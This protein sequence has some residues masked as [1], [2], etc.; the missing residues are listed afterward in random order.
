MRQSKGTTNIRASWANV[1]AGLGLLILASCT[2]CHA[3]LGGSLHGTV[4]DSTGAVIPAAPVEIE[5]A[6]THTVE[7]VASNEDGS[8]TF[9]GLDA[10]TYQVRAH[11]AG[12]RLYAHDGLVVQEG[13]DQEFN[14]TL[15]VARQTA[16]ITVTE[17]GPH[18][19][20]AETAR[21]ETLA[22]GKIA[23]IPVNGRS[24][25]DLLAL[26]A[27]VT[28]VGSAQPNAVVMSGCTSTPPSGDINPGT[29]SISGQRETSN[30]FIV[31]GSDVE[32]GFNMGS[33]IIP[34]LDSLEDLRVLT[35]NFDAE[36]GNYAGGQVLITTKS[37]TNR[38]H[39]STFEFLRNTHLDARNYFSTDRAIYDQNQWGGTFGGP[40][41]NDKA[42]FF[43]DYQGTRLTQ[44]LETGLIAVPS[45]AA[46]AG[47]FEGVAG[48][49]SGTV[50]G[51]SWADH[52]SQSLGYTVH[53]GE[54]YY[55]Q[56][57]ATPGQCVFPNA[58]IPAS[59]WSE[60]ARHLLQNVP[61]ANQGEGSFSTSA[62]T[63]ELRDD[64]A[65]TRIDA[66]TP[67]GLL[68]AYYFFDD[69][70]MDSP[71][72]TAQGGANVP[73]FNALTLGRAQLA[74]LGMTRTI[75]SNKVN[76]THASFLR[77]SNDVGI[78]QGGV[79]PSLA[80]QGFLDAAGNPS[81]Y[82]LSPRIEGIENVSLND[83]T[84]GVDTTG[85]AEAN[86]TMQVTDDFS[87]AAGQHTLKI[88]GGLHLDGINISPDAIYNGSFSFT[89]TETGSDFADFLLGRPSSY[90]QGDSHSF[91]LRNKYIGLY[92]QD[93]WRVRPGMTLNYGLR[94]DLLPPW[95]EK[96]NQLQ[97]LVL[98]EKSQ[99]YPGAPEGLVFPGDPGVPS[100]LAPAAHTNFAPRLGF[101]YSP[102]F[103]S[104]LLGKVLGSAGTTSL[105]TGYGMFYTAFEGLSA[106]IMSANPPYGY[107]Y[108]TLS[109]PLFSNPFVTAESGESTFQPFPEPIPSRGATRDHPNASLDWSQYSPITGV[110]SFY[111]R[112]VTPY[113][114]SYT[115]SIERQFRGDTVLKVSYVG[116]QAHH[117]LVLV[118]A[119]PANPS[120][121]LGLSRP[122]QVM[123]GT[124]TCGPFG[125][126]GKY[127]STSGIVIHGTRA[128]FRSLFDAITYQKTLG[129]S[130]YNAAEVS[131]RHHSGP[132]D[133][134]LGY[135]FSKSL[136]QSS[137][138][139]EAANPL[140]PSLSRAIS[141]FDMTQN[142]VV[143]Y[144]Y[145]LP[146]AHLLRRRGQWTEGWEL[147]GVTRFA[148][149]LP[150]TLFNNNDTSL[151]G[152]IPNGINNNGVDTP[153][154]A[155]GNPG[156]NT[157]PRGG[158]LAFDVSRFSLP[159]LGQI[160][161]A[162]RRFFHGPGMNN[163]D[164]AILKDFH[165]TESKTVE[166]RAEAFNVFNHAQFFGASAVNGN[167]SSAVFGHIVNAAEPRSVQ[168][169]AKFRF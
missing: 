41:K 71:Y 54:P 74:S 8:F 122:D 162:S 134:L 65:S 120:L 149:G 135:T 155:G 118:S 60:P 55:V 52:L 68:S 43:A 100:T 33:A 87:M 111:H 1:T 16:T 15:E 137:S 131:L 153:N 102:R 90:S 127:T 161:T 86:N 75:G 12:F 136:D 14:I 103:Q 97:T 21:G 5:N 37:G 89:G 107:D 156:V 96:Y 148:S 59:V 28:P 125:E 38:F 143:R 35:S 9:A 160:G 105:R 140:D 42:H 73:G 114:E 48:A 3:S 49:L 154:F 145:Q 123:A 126:G 92:A 150:V 11:L 18:L 151:L 133:F 19:D 163:F 112:N 26:Q 31:N 94:W 164:W 22:A 132:L 27:G 50:N 93:S 104:G 7:T 58:Q 169:A 64:K 152:S 53:S 6:V 110:P 61:L 63:E 17:A 113:S 142:L 40:L 29:L 20:P 46:R 157:D 45:N 4:T 91:Y 34:N 80:S 165:L 99:V 32:E 168:L 13:V 144:K 98:G 30:G 109:P 119:N 128:P 88:G 139:A 83:L 70:T 56:G 130:A 141:A 124:P 62:E 76:Q 166:L 47:D 95:R 81:I 44:G 159:A 84:F 147:S 78:P 67:L 66:T 106:G 69:Y 121:C 2:T 77:S 85:L 36:Y 10:G 23:S 138:L 158:R 129:N 82:A 146:I 101:A 24:F 117:L 116:T 72:P 108:T 39:G 79:G 25:T 57:C 51:Q 115:L 167:I